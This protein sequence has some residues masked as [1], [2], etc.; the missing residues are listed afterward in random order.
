MLHLSYHAVSHNGL[1]QR[2]D[3]ELMDDDDDEVYTSLHYEQSMHVPSQ[4]VLLLFQC[5][6]SLYVNGIVAGAVDFIVHKAI[7][8]V[9]KQNAK[10][11]SGGTNIVFQS[12]VKICSAAKVIK[13]IL[14]AI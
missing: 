2:Y 14:W 3:H 8:K 11:S 6:V 1:W 12:V 7:R 9:G 4:F 13:G 10:T 5:E